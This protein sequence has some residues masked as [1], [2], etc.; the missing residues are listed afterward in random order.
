[1][2]S[3]VPA[4]RQT[5][6]TLIELMTVLAVAAILAGTA[7]PSMKNLML[8]QQQVSALNAYVGSFNLARSHAVS[9]V[10]QVIACPSRDGAT[11]TG[12]LAWEHGWLLYQDD[13]R[14]RRL[15]AGEPVL[16]VAGPLRPGLTATSSIGRPQLVYRSDGSAAGSNL[17][18]TLCDQRGSDRAR[19]VVINNAGRPRTGPDELRRCTPPAA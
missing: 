5:G 2:N 1:M 3:P 13:N 7:V 11:C 17:R 6:L 9:H 19:S 10:S 16:S 18:L 8:H 12:G 14:N 4:P 15:D